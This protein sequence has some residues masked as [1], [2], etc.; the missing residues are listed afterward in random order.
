[1]KLGSIAPGVGKEHT[2]NVLYPQGEKG[3]E[4]YGEVLTHKGIRFMERQFH[5][6]GPKNFLKF[7][8]L[9]N[10]CLEKDFS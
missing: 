10:G 9:P 2:I 7:P 6:V 4:V 8:K 1:M 3:K 5:R